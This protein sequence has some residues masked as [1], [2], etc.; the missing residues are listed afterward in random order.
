M[1]EDL[2]DVESLREK[3]EIRRIE[4]WQK[5]RM[6]R[7]PMFRYSLDVTGYPTTLAE[8]K[9]YPAGNANMEYY[10]KGVYDNP[11][12]AVQMA[13]WRSD[14]DGVAIIVVDKDKLLVYSAD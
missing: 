7:Q 12:G 6:W 10:I 2:S 11:K 13:K 3:I 14:D 9:E 1:W 5:I 4:L 8:I